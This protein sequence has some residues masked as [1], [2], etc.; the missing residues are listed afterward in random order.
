MT[1]KLML[2]LHSYTC[3]FL[4]KMLSNSTCVLIYSLTK[5]VL[6]DGVIDSCSKNYVVFAGKYP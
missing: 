5:C 4:I 2:I 3:S 6:E 1:K